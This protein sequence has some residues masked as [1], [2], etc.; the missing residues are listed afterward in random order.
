MTYQEYIR[1]T[2]KLTNQKDNLYDIASHKLAIGDND[3]AK[4]IYAEID[5][6][7]KELDKLINPNDQIIDDNEL[8]LKFDS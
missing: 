1:L 4:R 7:Q 8:T 6:V 5:E 3:G 2:K